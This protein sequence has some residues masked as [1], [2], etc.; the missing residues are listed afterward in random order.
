MKHLVDID[1]G[2]LVRV[3]TILGTSTLKATVDTALRLVEESA[4]TRQEQRDRAIDD[5][6]ELCRR[7][8]LADRSEAW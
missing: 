1:D 8:P 5:W 7:I 2:L 6:A 4:P 3:R